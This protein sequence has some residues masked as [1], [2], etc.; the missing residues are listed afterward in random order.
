VFASLNNCSKRRREG[1]FFT[2]TFDA[3]DTT[4]VFI[5]TPAD[6]G[7]GTLPGTGS[8]VALHL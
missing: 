1:D 5:P 2:V 7:R 3:N 8:L 4:T 6:K